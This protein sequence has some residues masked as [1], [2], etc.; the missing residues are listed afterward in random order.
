M[1]RFEEFENFRVENAANAALK[2]ECRAYF[3]ESDIVIDNCARF[4]CKIPY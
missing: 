2:I 1:Q 4:V 3:L